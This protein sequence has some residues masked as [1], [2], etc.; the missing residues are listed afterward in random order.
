MPCAERLGSAGS[1]SRSPTHTRPSKGNRAVPLSGNPASTRLGP[2]HGD[3]RTG[4]ASRPAPRREVPWHLWL[5]RV[6]RGWRALRPQARAQD[7]CDGDRLDCRI[8]AVGRRTP[9]PRISVAGRS[10]HKAATSRPNAACVVTTW[11][12]FPSRLPISSLPRCR[13]ACRAGRRSAAQAQWS[14]AWHRR[15]SASRQCASALLPW[16]QP[17][18]AGR[19][20]SG[21]VTRREVPRASAARVPSERQSC[22]GHALHPPGGPSQCRRRATRR[23]NAA[24]IASRPAAMSPS[25]AGSGSSGGGS[26][27]GTGVPWTKSWW[28]GLPS[29]KT[30]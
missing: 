21:P 22:P 24:A 19:T 6:D 3:D 2:D 1:P 10:I 12:S 4:P 9:R 30:L 23:R 27:R 7:T 18:G 28:R 17:P 25:D 26:R 11:T 14:D 20:R 15:R 13:R 5:R 8:R 16:P 29:R